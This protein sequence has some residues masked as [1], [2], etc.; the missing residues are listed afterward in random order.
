[1]IGK[2]P[3]VAGAFIAAGHGCWGILL[4]PATGVRFVD[5]V[6]LVHFLDNWIWCFRI[7][8]RTNMI[9]WCMGVPVRTCNVGVG[10][11]WPGVVYRLET[12]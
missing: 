11:G 8:K 7:A 1:M 5:S 9:S 10:S 3:K 2:H 12:L 4:A 6:A